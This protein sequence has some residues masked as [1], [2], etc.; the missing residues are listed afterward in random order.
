M[1]KQIA[2]GMFALHSTN[3]S[4]IHRDLR[5][6]NILVDKD[7]NVKVA[8]FGLSVPNTPE[9]FA[10]RG[11]CGYIRCIAPEILTKREYSS[12]SDVYSY[13]ILLWELLTCKEPYE[14]VSMHDIRKMIIADIKPDIEEIKKLKVTDTI[15]SLIERCW[16]KDPNLRPS[17]GQILDTL[18]EILCVPLDIF[19]AAERGKVALVQKKLDAL[20]RKKL[21]ITNQNVKT[22]ADDP[23]KEALLP[24][25]FKAYTEPSA[26]ALESL[27]TT[28]NTARLATS[29]GSVEDNLRGS[30]NGPDQMFKLQEIISDLNGVIERQ[31]LVARRRALAESDSHGRTALIYSAMHGFYDVVEHLVE[32]GAFLDQ[33]DGDFKTALHYAVLNSRVDIV[34]Y[35]CK[36]LLRRQSLL[37]PHAQSPAWYINVR[38]RQGM[39]P[40]HYACIRGNR[41]V[42]QTLIDS[43]AD[44]YGRNNLQLTSLHLACRHGL[45]HVVTL[46]LETE[47]KQMLTEQIAPEL[48]PKM[49]EELEDFFKKRYKVEENNHIMDKK[50]KNYFKNTRTNQKYSEL[51]NFVDRDRRSCLHYC[52]FG[53]KENIIELLLQYGADVNVKDR[54]GMSALHYASFFANKKLVKVLLQQGAKNNEFSIDML[55]ISP[56]HC[57]CFFGDPNTVEALA[58]ENN[59]DMQDDEG[60]SPLHIAAMHG[61]QKV[62]L[63]LLQKRA[64]PFRLDK[65]GFNCLHHAAMSGHTA[66]TEILLQD[67]KFMSKRVIQHYNPLELL[68]SRDPNGMTALHW[69]VYQGHIQ[70]VQSLLAKYPQLAHS[71]DLNGNTPFHCACERGNERIAIMLAESGAE[72]FQRTNDGTTPLHYAAMSGNV[73]IVKFLVESGAFV[74]CLNSAKQTALHAACIGG[75]VEVVMFLLRRSAVIMHDHFG[76]TPMSYALEYKRD[77]IIL[78]LV[79]GGAPQTKTGQGIN[80]S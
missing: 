21:Y 26:S 37:A 31:L 32:V 3:P 17:F 70:T 51:V 54:Y 57:A 30:G 55:G 49:V 47:Q 8:D 77:G 24:P 11:R 48:V 42:I 5:A 45:D 75:S 22:S 50:D 38:D 41:E 43:G 44:I 64:D 14:G 12:K 34:Q 60:N 62:A 59:I 65:K 63:V 36:C 20:S 9:S 15:V 79:N 78:Y 18:D 2:R 40:L 19:E 67:V 33:Q 16:D 74:N 29:W 80:I 10:A 39:T 76:R 66:V 7:Y 35:I 52:A 69:A 53:A 13:A 72:L 68:E 27:Q 56:L 58:N 28:V 1:A 23:E 61:H 4:I 71:E 25:D 73:N 46:L 6:A